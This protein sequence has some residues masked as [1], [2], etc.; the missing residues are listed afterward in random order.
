[1]I[2]CVLAPKSDPI[3]ITITESAFFR[4]ACCSI[5][6]LTGTSLV[7]IECGILSGSSLRGRFAAEGFWHT[8]LLPEQAE[9]YFRT[10]FQQGLEW[11][12]TQI[13]LVENIFQVVCASKNGAI[14][15][16]Q[17][18]IRA[19]P[20]C[21]VQMRD[22]VTGANGNLGPPI[23]CLEVLVPSE[24]LCF[25]A[26]VRLEAGA[27]WNSW[28]FRELPRTGLPSCVLCYVAAK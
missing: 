14:K 11:R 13:M 1:V 6:R 25:T 5:K 8:P 26:G 2:R 24:L 7:R 4:G 18:E 22:T 19:G 23:P 9:S 12:S 27:L 21:T 15:Q 28:R 10:N 20:D 17:E 16:P 3:A